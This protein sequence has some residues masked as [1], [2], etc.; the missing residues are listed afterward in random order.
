MKLARLL[1]SAGAAAAISVCA[2]VRSNAVSSMRV[3]APE[4]ERPASER[5]P[6]PARPADP[7]KAA[8][9]ARINQ[10]RV[11]FGQ[12]PVEWDDAASRAGDAFCAAQIQEKTRGH[13]L[14]DGIPPYARM[15]FAGVFALHAQNSVSWIT[16]GNHFHESTVDLA[17][18]G[19][20]QMMA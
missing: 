17:L 12:P 10:D 11:R 9:F 18:E 20:A 3:R 4:L 7:V 14:T 15:T 13:Y 1:T 2:A 8:V 19:E 6:D 5:Y 16:T